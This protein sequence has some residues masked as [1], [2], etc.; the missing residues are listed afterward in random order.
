MKKF[1]N[2]ALSL[3]IILT[4]IGGSVLASQA[5]P[6]SQIANPPSN[7]QKRIGVGLAVE[8]M[9]SD[10]NLTLVPAKSLGVAG[11]S[12][13]QVARRAQGALCGE[14]GALFSE[15]YYLGLRVSWRYSGVTNTAQSPIFMTNF[16]SHTFKINQYG[17]FLIKPGYK[18]TRKFMLYGLFGPV[19]ANWTHNSDQYRNTTLVNSLKINRT[20]FGMGLGFGLEYMV[21]HNCA[22]S[23][24]YTHNFFGTSSKTTNISYRIPGLATVSGGVTKKVQPSFSTIAARLTVFFNL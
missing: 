2:S 1:I 15:E 6:N 14:F 7:I 19:I 11:T 24:D 21:H 22:F 5:Q 10:T 18:L 8:Y 13:S 17:D 9:N 16:F 20:S 12:Q 4:Q 23:L 3:F